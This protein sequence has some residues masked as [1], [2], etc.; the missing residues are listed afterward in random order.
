[1]LAQADVN[2]PYRLFNQDKYW[3]PYGSLDPLYGSWPYL[4]AHQS[5][6]DVSVVWMNS[7]ETY[8]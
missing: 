1:M 3:H 8:V 5:T 6:S 7:S 2:D 4:T